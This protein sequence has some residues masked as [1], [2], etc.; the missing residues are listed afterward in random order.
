MQYFEYWVD[1]ISG[2]ESYKGDKVLIWREKNKDGRH[3][4]NIFPTFEKIDAAW[5]LILVSSMFNT[6]WIQKAVL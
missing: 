3:D 2:F 5:E 6:K 4:P 1:R